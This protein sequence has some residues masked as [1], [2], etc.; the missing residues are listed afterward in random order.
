MCICCSPYQPLNSLTSPFFYGIEVR[1][2]KG[3]PHIA[4]CSAIMLPRQI[5]GFSGEG[6]IPVRNMSVQRYVVIVNARSFQDTV[7]S[8]R[9][10]RVKFR[11][12]RQIRGFE[13]ATSERSGAFQV[14][15]ED[16]DPTVHRVDVVKGRP[17]TAAVVTDYH[18]GLDSRSQT[19]FASSHEQ[20]IYALAHDVPECEFKADGRA[21]R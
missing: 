8:M 21:F 7:R 12:T 4:E 15:A 5:S 13:D 18:D 9:G 10:V 16:T 2:T 11:A 20:R 1:G 3:L 6:E 19:L 17:I 14:G